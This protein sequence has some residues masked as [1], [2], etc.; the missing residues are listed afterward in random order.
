MSREEDDNEPSKRPAPT[1]VRRVILH[2]HHRSVWYI[3]IMLVEH[4]PM[5][6][7][8][9]HYCTGLWSHF[10]GVVMFLKK[11]FSP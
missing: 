10:T 7:I 3:K 8:N 5:M 11:F 9:R 6:H 4:A 2:R 1:K